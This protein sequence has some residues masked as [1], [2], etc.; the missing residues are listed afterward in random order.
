MNSVLKQSIVL[1]ILFKI[2]TKID[3]EQKLLLF[4]YYTVLTLN[5]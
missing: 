4:K 5:K 3:S 1:D 2:I